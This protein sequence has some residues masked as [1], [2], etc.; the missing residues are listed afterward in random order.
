MRIE[1]ELLTV[2]KPGDALN[3]HSSASNWKTWGLFRIIQF[4]QWRKWR[5][6]TYRPVWYKDI[7]SQLYLGDGKVLSVEAP[8]AVIKPLRI[9]NRTKTITICRYLG[10]HAEFNDVAIAVIRGCA[11]VIEGTPYDYGQLADIF[12]RELGYLEKD[13]RFFDF[14]RKWRVCSTGVRACLVKWWDNLPEGKLGFPRPGGDE[15]V[16][17]T[18][19]ADL[20][21]HK[22][23]VVVKQIKR[24][25]KWVRIDFWRRRT[26]STA[27]WVIM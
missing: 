17:D 22:T 7:H 9:G 2:L 12:F 3:T 19:P 8:R 5:R 21:M 15:W 1:E 20:A 23:F 10:E 18:A 4:H 26:A 25:K 11:E 6:C 13:K 24:P 27:H 16:A 14:S